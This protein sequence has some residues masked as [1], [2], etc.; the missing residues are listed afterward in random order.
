MSEIYEFPSI[1]IEVQYSDILRIA[2][3][4]GTRE[5]DMH[6]IGLRT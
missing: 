1:A 2:H 6:D 4:E 5:F 3:D